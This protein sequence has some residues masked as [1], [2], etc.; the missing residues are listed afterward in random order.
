MLYEVLE[1][2]ERKAARLSVGVP[3]DGTS[4]DF[5]KLQKIVPQALWLKETDK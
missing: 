1:G 2:E 5:A 4:V 3:N